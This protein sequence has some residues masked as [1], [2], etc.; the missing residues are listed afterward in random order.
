MHFILYKEFFYNINF[1]TNDKNQFGDVYGI[2]LFPPKWH[3][4][5]F[6]SIMFL[7]TEIGFLLT[8]YI[9]I[10]KETV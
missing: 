2:L 10:S 9:G 7:R 6:P 1:L 3:F 8:N 4:V 5:I